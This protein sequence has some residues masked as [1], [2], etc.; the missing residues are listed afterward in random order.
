MVIKLNIL[1][2]NDEKFIEDACRLHYKS[3]K[4]N[5]KQIKNYSKWYYGK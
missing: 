1:E 2:E 3:K 4:C 5:T